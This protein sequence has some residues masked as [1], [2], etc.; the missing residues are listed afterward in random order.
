MKGTVAIIE[1]D[2]VQIMRNM[3]LLKK[4]PSETSLVKQNNL[5]NNDID[6]D[7]DFDTSTLDPPIAPRPQ[8]PRRERPQRDRRPPVRYQDFQR[9]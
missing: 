9:Y 2:Q 8:F 5:R 7:L 3:S 6:D 1:R 4:I